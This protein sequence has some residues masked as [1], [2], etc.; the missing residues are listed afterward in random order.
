VAGSSGEVFAIVRFGVK[1]GGW[2]H[3]RML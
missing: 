2:D 3:G 1:D